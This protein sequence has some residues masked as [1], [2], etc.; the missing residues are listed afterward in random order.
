MTWKKEADIPQVQG[1]KPSSPGVLQ[2]PQDPLEGHVS[3]K[4]PAWHR[5]H[6]PPTPR[7][8]KCSSTHHRTSSATVNTNTH[9]PAGSKNNQPF[10]SMPHASSPSQGT[11]LSVPCRHHGATERG[12]GQGVRQFHALCF[13]YTVRQRSSLKGIK[14][15][16]PSLATNTGLQVSLS[17]AP[18]TW[19]VSSCYQQVPHARRVRRTSG[20]SQ[21]IAALTPTASPSPPRERVYLSQAEELVPRQKR[22]ENHNPKPELASS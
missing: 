4:S 20:I 7:A 12:E 9:T 22:H 14:V 5:R 3:A 17:G 10:H 1:S 18:P 21:P 15:R 6:F 13:V 8:P 11:P 19:N 16:G 2:S